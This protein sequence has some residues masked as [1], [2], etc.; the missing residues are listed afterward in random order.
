MK[1]FFNG[2]SVMNE[3][4]KYIVTNKPGLIDQLLLNSKD[5]EYKIN[6]AWIKYSATGL[7]TTGKGLFSVDWSK[8]TDVRVVEPKVEVKK[9]KPKE[10]DKPKPKID[11]KWWA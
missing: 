7:G 1:I 3:V 5:F 4:L 11:K 10:K 6:G 9:T 8:I 2:V